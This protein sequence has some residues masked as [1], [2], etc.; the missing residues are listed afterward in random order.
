[1]ATVKDEFDIVKA[2]SDAAKRRKKTR[3]IP[4]ASAFY[5]AGN[6]LNSY[7]G[8]SESGQSGSSSGGEGAGT[9]GG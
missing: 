6:T 4:A 1:M 2:A 8:G 7:Y 5:G 9:A 3:V